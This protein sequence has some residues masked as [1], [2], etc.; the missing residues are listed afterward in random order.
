MTADSPA[1]ID[2]SDPTQRPVRKF[3]TTRHGGHSTGDY[4]SFNLGM[5]VGDDP[6]AV[7][8]NRKRLAQIAGLA[9][10]QLVFMEQL[11]TNNV[12]VIDDVVDLFA[13]WQRPTEVDEASLESL[14]EDQKEYLDDQ[15]WI[16]IP[17][18]DAIIT[19]R[20]QVGLVVQVAD[21]VPV[22]LSDHEASITA[23]VH[24]GR[25]GARN[26]I[27]AKT[28]EKMIELGAVAERIHVLVGPAAGHNYELPPEMA[29]DVEEHLPGSLC[30]TDKGTTGV[31]LRRGIVNQLLEY[32]ITNIYADPR[33]TLRDEEFFSYR[34]QGVTGR[35]VGLTFLTGIK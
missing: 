32:G 17:V 21:C 18:T 15:G 29:S 7:S 19:T 10:E 6:S 11:H 5:H 31:D 14:S 8:A 23:A 33:D 30:T 34:R 9:P 2:T 16:T 27:I 35:Q 28:V 12:T 25:L 1:P 26:G 4:D 13:G 24:A 20:P 3:I 22:L